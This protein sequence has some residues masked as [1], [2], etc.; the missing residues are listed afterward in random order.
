MSFYEKNKSFLS[1]FIIKELSTKSEDSG[2]A[3]E[4][5]DNIT[6]NGKPNLQVIIGDKVVFIHDQKDPFEEASQW[7]Q[8]IIPQKGMV[9][10]V[11]GFGLA[12]HIEALLQKCRGVEDIK[13]IVIEPCKDLLI[14]ALQIRDLSNV[15]SNP[16]LSL[17]TATKEG[18]LIKQ[19]EM[20]LPINLVTSGNV[21]VLL[22]ESLTDNL[23][24]YN[25][26]A[27]R[28]RRYLIDAEVSRNT[29]LAFSTKWTKN[30]F[31]NLHSVLESRPIINL[32]NKFTDIPIIV[33]AAGPSLD[34]NIHLLPK[35]KGKAVIIAVGTSYKS[36]CKQG[37][38]PDFVFAID[39]AEAQAEIFKDIEESES[40][41]CYPPMVY[42][43][44]PSLFPKKFLIKTS[45]SIEWIN[46]I[47]GNVGEITGGPSVAN[48]A[49]EFATK[50]GGNPIIFIGQDLALSENRTHAK[51][52]IH[53][54][55]VIT[56]KS[57]L[58]EV[59][60][61][62]GGKVFTRRDF[63]SML[64]CYQI[65]IEQLGG[66]FKVIDA[67]EGGALIPGTDIMPFNEVINHY[68]TQNY[69]ISDM[70]NKYA[71]KKI[72]ENIDLKELEQYFSETILEINEVSSIARKGER[73]SIDLQAMFVEN[74][75]NER[76]LAKVYDRI[77][78]VL[79]KV[80]TM[81]HFCAAAGL[82]I[83]YTGFILD[84]SKK[85]ASNYPEFSRDWGVTS[86]KGYLRYFEEIK[87]V[88][89]I[90]RFIEDTMGGLS[91]FGRIM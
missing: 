57:F 86:A 5:V 34:K 1:E 19:L 88:C 61:I 44:V 6:D 76:K 78:D 14:R 28:I 56:D 79:K 71:G 40:W 20:V 22:K 13:V 84:E 9:F 38:E 82:V 12:Y 17:V 26:Y 47:T 58:V 49:F 32:Y 69:P 24:I 11:F 63:H 59:E 77:I 29:L 39:G 7:V 74:R 67:T 21:S 16:S 23:S 27:R 37:I 89:Y 30:N 52:T 4:V 80:K 10:L 85:E 15:L 62:D 90:S 68:L 18:T 73:L 70:I 81:K 43:Q 48:Y 60:S 91:S 65:M 2:T 55:N 72:I 3:Y 87:N 46:K 25:E 75:T 33:V 41:L 64:T 53:E 51:N 54:K 36:V 31:E 8:N 83:N 42:P 66:K 50:I 35:V 45:S